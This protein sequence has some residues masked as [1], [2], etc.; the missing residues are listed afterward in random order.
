VAELEE[1]IAQLRRLLAGE[2]VVHPKTGVAYRL[3]FGSEQRIPI[4]VAAAS[5]RSLRM[6]GRV[7][8]GV[9]ACVGVDPRLVEAALHHIAT[10]AHEAGRDPADVRTVLWTATAISDDGAAA[11]DLVR[12]FTASVV[13]PPLVARLDSAELEA[14]E[15]IRSHYDYRAHMR[16]DAEHR[17][18]VPD[19]LV[20][21]FAVAGTPDDCRSQLRAIL[22]LPVDEVSFVPFVRP[23][24]DRGALMRRLAEEVLPGLQ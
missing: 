17:E 5:P 2:D 23:G 21:R 24:D 13:I 10:G 15:A 14:V 18:L 7:A 22:A 12:A 19:A 20:T 9:V 4:Y 3:Q 1:R 8:D 6:A 11:R 16:T